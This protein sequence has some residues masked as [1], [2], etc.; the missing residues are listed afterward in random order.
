MEVYIIRHT[1][2]VLGREYCYG[3]TDVGLA[4]TF[5]EE[6]II[7]KNELPSTFDAVFCS[8]LSRC[9]KLGEA[10]QYP[11]IQY[12]DLLK[13]MNFGDWDGKRWSEI[14]PQELSAWLGDFVNQ[15]TPNGENFGML[16]QR[17]KQFLDQLRTE[18]YERVLLITHAGVIRC[19]WSLIL[20]IP[21]K[22]IF[23]FPIDFHETMVVKLNQNP[24]FDG[25]KRKK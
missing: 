12:E 6:A 13:E 2:V 21:L 11:Q 3:Q 15:A 20:E 25:I 17:V 8:P 10:L 7:Y 14:D 24:L 5:L 1:K 23:R 4:D 22:N 19:I 9:K 18:K 16:A